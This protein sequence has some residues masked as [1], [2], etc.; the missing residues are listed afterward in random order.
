MQSPN[1]LPHPPRINH[2]LFL[3][4]VGVQQFEL[5][6][7]NQSYQDV[8]LFQGGVDI[9][10]GYPFRV[11]ER[12]GEFLDVG[13]DEQQVAEVFI[14][15]F[16]GDFDG[17]AFAQVVNVGFE[18]QAEAGDGWGSE[19]FRPSADAL[20][21][22]VRL[23]IVDFTCNA[24]KAG[25]FGGGVD[26]EPGV[27]GDAVSADAGAGLQD[28]D[29]GVAVGEIDQFPD[30]DP[31]FVADQREFVGVG[32]VDVAVGVF[33]EFAEF[34]GAR[35][36]GEAGAFDEGFVEPCGG[37]GAAGGHAADDSVVADEFL[38][39]VAGQDAFGAVGDLNVGVVFLLLREG[40]IRALGGEPG[41]EFFGRADG[42]GG[43]ENDEVAGFEYRGDEF[44]GGF[45]VAEVGL[46]VFGEGG[47][48]G[49]Q[50]GVRGFGL[51]GGFEVAGAD[52]GSHD[53]VE[54]GFDDVDLA[55]VDGVDGFGVDVDANDLLAPGGE[56][57]GG[58]QADVAET[59]DG[60]ALVGVRG[61]VPGGRWGGC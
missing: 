16:Q 14:G 57:G 7:I 43:F 20:D 37:F 32:D 53:D 48:D 24:Y 26:D 22:V 54:V 31:E 61:G 12:F 11:V 18:R 30:V 39:D 15:E 4:L 8:R 19:S 21:D 51:G 56:D 58:G 3:Q 36:G 38:E 25:L 33:G 9:D 42:A 41:G 49:D 44:G 52:G 1:P 47:G 29:A 23:A 13:F 34:G 5:V 27:D 6:M 40:E 35:M 45:D 10:Q 17:G 28:V 50:E 2:N 46:V 60:D 55:L 59:D